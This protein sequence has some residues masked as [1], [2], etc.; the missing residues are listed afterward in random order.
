MYWN[1]G[2][3]FSG[4]FNILPICLLSDSLYP[5]TSQ[6]L[7]ISLKFYFLLLLTRTNSDTTN[8]EFFHDYFSLFMISVSIFFFILLHF[9]ICSIFQ[10]F[11]SE[12]FVS[13]AD[14]S[15]ILQEFRPLT[16]SYLWFLQTIYSLPPAGG[17]FLAYIV[18]GYLLGGLHSH[19]DLN[20]F[21]YFIGKFTI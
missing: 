3:S 11:R 12:F 13:A 6:L 16:S 17:V 20:P 5:I 18:P 4:I 21:T 14:C 15:G 10:L 8:P 2:V 7:F 1:I 9:I 19:S